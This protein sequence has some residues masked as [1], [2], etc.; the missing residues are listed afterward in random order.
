MKTI[1]IYTIV[2]RPDI[3]RATS[4]TSE[5]PLTKAILEEAIPDVVV[6]TVSKDWGDRTVTLE[7][8]RSEH[9]E[10]LNELKR[11]IEH[12]GFMLLSAMASEWASEVMDDA[13]AAAILGFAGEPAAETGAVAFVAK[14]AGIIA[15]QVTGKEVRRVLAEFQATQDYWGNWSVHQIVGQRTAVLSTARRSSGSAA[16]RVGQFGEA[17]PSASTIPSWSGSLHRHYKRRL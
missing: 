16:V 12:L 2:V 1:H 4:W 3:R 9:A 13:V 10:A 8:Q 14:T 11:T 7:L 5:P 17:H 6:H 15:G